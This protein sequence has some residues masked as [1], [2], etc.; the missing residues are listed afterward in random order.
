MIVIATH[1]Y[2]D[3]LL[4]Q[5]VIAANLLKQNLCAAVSQNSRFGLNFSDHTKLTNHSSQLSQHH[6]DQCT[7]KIMDQL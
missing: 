5:S 2:R 3:I 4:T 6:A 7:E 1:S